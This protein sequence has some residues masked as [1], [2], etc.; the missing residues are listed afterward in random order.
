[1]PTRMSGNYLFVNPGEKCFKVASNFTN[2]FE[3]GSPGATDYYLEAAIVNDEFIVNADF[4]VPGAP[5]RCKLENNFP[6]ASG[7]TQQMTPTGYRILDGAQQLVLGLSAKNN[8][9]LIQ[10]KIYDGAGQVVAEDVG[11]D[12]LVYHGPAVLGKVDGTRGIVLG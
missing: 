5:G 9:C 12:F 8:I 10:G 3:V 11:D 7:L 2:Y 1:M 4:P 6:R